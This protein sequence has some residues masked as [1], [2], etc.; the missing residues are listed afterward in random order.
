MNTNSLL[1]ISIFLGSNAATADDLDLIPDS[2]FDDIPEV[3]NT[4][5][6]LWDFRLRTQ[7]QGEFLVDQ[8][9][10]D[11]NV[12]V[13]FSANSTIPFAKGRVTT[14]A[15]IHTLYNPERAYKM[16]DEIDLDL[17][18]LYYSTTVNASSFIDVGRI[19]HRSG[20]ALGYNPTDYF[21]AHLVVDNTDTDAR[22]RSNNR[23]GVFGFRYEKNFKDKSLVLLI[24]PKIDNESSDFDYYKSNPSLRGLISYSSSSAT[25]WY[26]Q[27]DYFH[28]DY[29]YMGF[30]T[31]V[32]LSESV[33]G[34]FESSFSRQRSILSNYYAETNSS[35][36]AAPLITDAFPQRN[37]R[38]RN[39]STLGI[40]YTSTSDITTNIEYHYSDLAATVD[41]QENWYAL[42]TGHPEFTGTLWAMRNNYAQIEEPFV[43]QTLWLRS[44]W[45]EP[46]EKVNLGLIASYLLDDES[47]SIHGNIKYDLSDSVDLLFQVSYFNGSSKSF[48]GTLPL[49]YRYYAQL[50]WFF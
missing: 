3:R 30:S 38:I 21:K 24:S 13:N 37:K 39:Q 45:N 49:D 18:E 32:V 34:Y 44:L 46:I 12:Y 22:S 47:Y 8:D 10:A 4:S 41:E 43:K 36:N 15:S 28:A 33:L 26:Y 2:I 25:G 9:N 35:S 16:R 27:L 23:L 5:V 19:N 48:Y 6:S 11:P 50:N 29:D 7:L 17:K 42:I 20:L 40:S 31:S 14:D 1:I